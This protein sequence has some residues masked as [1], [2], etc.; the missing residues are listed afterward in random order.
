LLL[1]VLLIIVNS[2]RCRW[3]YI[4]KGIKPSRESVEP[5]VRYINAVIG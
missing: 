3:Q 4:R 5:A 1:P 2:M